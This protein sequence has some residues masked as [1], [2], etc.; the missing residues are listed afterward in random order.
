MKR[1]IFIAFLPSEMAK[2]ELTQISSSFQ[3]LN[4]RLIATENLHLTLVFIG[5]V[6]EE[7]LLKI[8]RLVKRI[9]S[10]YSPFLVN[11]TKIICGPNSKRPRMI[12]ATGERHKTLHRLYNDIKRI[13]SLNNVPFDN[14]HP[15]RIHLTLARARKK[16]LSGKEIYKKIDISFPINEIL[17]MES[18]LNRRGV[19][20][21]RLESFTLSKI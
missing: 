20:Y 17:L 8:K 10:N 5:W 18:K 14:R 6:E 4:V 7:I 3:K 16:E 15:F 11:L 9:V 12:W 2:K 13:F 21:K 1:R 19:E